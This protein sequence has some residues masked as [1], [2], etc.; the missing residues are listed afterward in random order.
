MRYRLARPHST[1]A[2]Q[3]AQPAHPQYMARSTLDSRLW[4]CWQIRLHV[5]AYGR[6]MAELHGVEALKM[7][8]HQHTQ[9]GVPGTISPKRGQHDGQHDELD[10]Q[11]AL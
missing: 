3:K 7:N 11:H 6:F 8:T 1:E 5:L 4:P 10:L 9:I 2:C